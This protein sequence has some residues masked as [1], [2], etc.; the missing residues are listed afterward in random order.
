MVDAL[1]E[2]IAARDPQGQGKL[3]RAA[4]ID[5]SQQKRADELAAANRALENEDVERKWAEEALRNSESTNRALL[6]AVPDLMFR[7]RSDGTFL[8]Y[9]GR[10]ESLYTTPERFL[11]KTVNEVLPP[12]VAQPLMACTRET[13]A[14]GKVELCEYALDIRGE[15]CWFEARVVACS[16]DEVLHIVRDITDRKRAEEALQAALQRSYHILSGMYSAVL[17]VTDEGRV[18]FANQ[19]ICRRF[20]LEDAPSDLAGLGASDM[21]EKIKHAYLHPDA[22]VVRIREILDRGQPVTGEEI[23]MKDGRTCLRDFVPLRVQG[24]SYGRLWIHTDI[25][26]ANRPK[27]ARESKEKLTLA[28]RSAN[29]GAWRLDLR[30]QQRHFDEQICRCLGID[31]ASFRGTEE[32]FF[33]AVHPDDHRQLRTAGP[34][35]RHRRTIRSRIS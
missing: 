1:V 14:S 24:K 16:A 31:A 34:D 17:L 28:L 30:N 11:G 9:T 29:M 21:I 27:G 26:D 20:G 23:A 4:V 22:A 18:E 15:C 25:T 33:T 35:Y 6:A 2:G 32:E 12:Q 19:A 3:C 8:G 5:V 13:I 10:T 7:V